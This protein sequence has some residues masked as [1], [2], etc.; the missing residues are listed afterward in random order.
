M[1]H[2]LAVRFEDE[3]TPG[4]PTYPVHLMLCGGTACHA[5]KSLEIKRRFEEE[6]AKRRLEDRVLVIETGCNG[7]CAQGPVM[8]VFPGMIFY[9]FLDPADVEEIIEEHVVKGFPVKRLM[10]HDA[11]TGEAVPRLEDIPFFASQEARVLRNRGRIAAENIDEYI[12]L[13]GYKAALKALSKMTPEEIIGQ[14][15]ASGLRGRGGA[16]FP[17]GL[18]WNFASKSK[19]DE[20]YILCNADEG[21]PGAFMDRSVLEADPHAV[22]EGMIVAAKAIGAHQGYIYCRAEYPLAVRRLHIAIDQARR[23]GLL[24]KNILGLG[25]DFDIELYR[26]AGAFVC[27]EETA[28]MISIEGKRGMPRPRPPFPAVQGLW[29]KPTVLNNVETLASIPQ[30]MLN[31][32]RW[33]AKMGTTRSKG[34]KIFALTGDINNVGL[35]EVPM[36][37]SLGKIIYEIAGGMNKGKS[38]KAVQLGG[39]SGGCV[40]S[41]HLNTPVDYESIVQLGAI[42]GSGG[43]IVMDE[44]KCMVDVA[45]FFMEFCV[46]ESCGKCTP[47]RVGTRQM[48]NILTRICKGQGLEGDIERLEKWAS[49]I[50]NSALCG[51]GQTAPNPVLSTLRYFRKE[52]E[53]HIY[54]KRCPAVVC[55]DLF[56]APC[57]H[58]CP[59]GMEVPSYVALIR[60]GRLDD[61]YRVLLRTN[62]FPS[63]C[64]RVCDHK[65]EMKCRRSTLDEPVNIKYL[66]RFITDNAFRPKYRPVESRRAERVAVIGAGPAGLTAARELAFRGYQVSVFEALPEPGGMLRYGIPAYRLPRDVLKAEIQ[67]ILDLGVELRCGCQVGRDVTWREIKEEFEAVYL[68][69]GAHQSTMLGV[70]GEEH[71]GVIGA[72]EFLRQVE[73]GRQKAI[74]KRVAVVGGGN[75]AVDAAR[76]ALRMGAEEVTILYRRLREDMPAQEEEIKAAEEEGVKIEYLV[77]PI[78]IVSENGNLR[79]I[80]SQRMSLGDFDASGRR[81]P[82][83][84]PG[85]EFGLEVD[86]VI[87]AIGQKTDLPFAEQVGEE[88][89]TVSKAG[90]IQVRGRSR[91]RTGEAMVFAGGDAVTGPNTVIWAIAAGRDAAGEIDAAIRERTGDAPWAPLREE[92]A[93]PGLSEE[94]VREI[95]RA[96]M[97]EIPARNR[98]HDFREVELGFTRKVAI[99]E[100]GRCLR[101]DYK[102]PTV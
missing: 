18:K 58:A 96:E 41:S 59:A 73:L 69:V 76:V 43:M 39:P 1:A 102:E 60:D 16:G 38:F 7:F 89:F 33:F 80:V 40:P 65:C 57:Q 88:E 20:K 64:G 5:S 52:Y 23:Y 95:P 90:L 62:P 83:P 32:G 9:Q 2:F 74:G 3:I 10:Y 29:K 63:V 37:T 78:R 34:T 17:T 27:G 14:V 68:A 50:Q 4:E 100:A 15:M 87:R 92:I 42:V 12:G 45:R 24:G 13:D 75:S 97:P 54:E 53:A 44:D 25:F 66:K 51:L 99:T 101:C 47:C 49:I 93:I 70:T 56:D 71:E 55:S 26:G 31:G 86:Q 19:S 21:D 6:I 72:V 35:A 36:G 22:L 8:N 81:R 82:L 28:L 61:A 85:A 67:A 84:I 46:D 98:R 94:E 30:I 91:S 48:L 77:A 79:K 11:K